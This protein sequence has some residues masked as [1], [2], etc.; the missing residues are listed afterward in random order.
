MSDDEIGKRFRHIV[1]NEGPNPMYHLEVIYQM[2]TLW[3][4]MYRLIQDIRTHR[5]DNRY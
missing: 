5:N 1:S 2:K 4:L 3:P